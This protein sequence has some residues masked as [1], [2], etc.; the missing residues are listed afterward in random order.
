VS[1]HTRQLETELLDV[2]PVED[3]RAQRSR[4]ELLLVNRLMGHHWLLV[5]ALREAA[6]KLGRPPHIIVELGAGDGALTCVVA[7][8]LSREWR[9]V[10]IVLVDRQALVTTE[11]V[12]AFAAYGWRARALT[13]DLANGHAAAALPAADIAF[14]N[15]VL[16]HFDDSRLRSLLALVEKKCA[17]FVAAE[18]RRALLGV[19]ASRTLPLIG[20]GPVSR[21]DAEASVRAGF[22]HDELSCLWPPAPGWRLRDRPAG[23]FSH[24]FIA[25]RDPPPPRA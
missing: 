23:L 9:D 5:H 1:L 25:Q 21:H 6:E 11:T 7:R 10:E 2:L 19:A 12:R 8:A 24:L 4:K 16:H 14:A 17:A 15:L 22:R 3:P 13:V 20:C 18:P